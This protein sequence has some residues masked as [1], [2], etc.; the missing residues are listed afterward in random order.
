MKRPSRLKMAFAA[1]PD[2]EAPTDADGDNVYVVEVSAS[3]GTDT[4]SLVLEISVEDAFEGRV[5]DGPVAGASV[6]VD[7]NCNDT[8]DEGE[9][10]G[11]TDDAGFFKVGKVQA[12][13]LRLVERT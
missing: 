13:C 5:I 4:T 12:G 2:F 6:F 7:L 11:E 9:P 10:S 3:D 8:Q 1:A